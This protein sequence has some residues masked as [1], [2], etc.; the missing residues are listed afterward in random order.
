MLPSSTSPTAH[1]CF[2]Q[3]LREAPPWGPGWSDLFLH[4]LVPLRNTAVEPLPLEGLW[5]AVDRSQYAQG[6]LD[7]SSGDTRPYSQLLSHPG[8]SQCHS[9]S[10]AQRVGAEAGRPG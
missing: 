7:T 6:Q 10:R 2:L 5:E 8:T 3:P 9:N 4:T 1:S